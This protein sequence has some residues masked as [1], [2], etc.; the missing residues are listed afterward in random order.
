MTTRKTAP[1]AGKAEPQKPA[2]P[3]APAP[4]AK[5]GPVMSADLGIR[6][7]TPRISAPVRGPQTGTGSMS[8][9]EFIAAFG[10]AEELASFKQAIE[11]RRARDASS[12]SWEKC[13]H[14]GLVLKVRPDS[15]ENDACPKCNK[16][17]TAAGGHFK[18]ME[19]SAVDLHLFEEAKKEAA[20][21]ERLR[22]AEFNTR[23]QERGKAGLAPLTREEFTK[24]RQAEFQQLKQR[25]RDL[26]EIS[27]LY[28]K[29][30]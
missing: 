21:I 11:Q 28:R 26:G 19:T 3:A 4:A 25:G 30:P 15:S 6:H 22:L 2:P 17:R 27:G 29:Q 24:Q 5:P 14:C 7:D 13:D 9:A 20:I 16:M 10:T 12:W 8:P 1:A 18:R 23:N